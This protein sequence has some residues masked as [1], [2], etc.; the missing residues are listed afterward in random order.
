MEHLDDQLEKL[1]KAHL[2]IVL[3]MREEIVDLKKKLKELK[4]EKG[5]ASPG[6]DG[7]PG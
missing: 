7:T 4:S 5:P 3:K 2:K 6:G 1:I